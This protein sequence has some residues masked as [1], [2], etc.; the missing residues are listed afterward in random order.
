M[1]AGYWIVGD[2]DILGHPS[3]GR[4]IHV[5]LSQPQ[6]AARQGLQVVARL[7]QLLLNYEGSSRGGKND[8]KTPDGDVDVTSFALGVNYWATRHLRVGLNYT[9][10]ALPTHAPVSPLHEVSARVGVQF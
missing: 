6:R 3:Y 2:H 4:P 7:D 1:Q 5:D 8:P 9:Y 10:Y